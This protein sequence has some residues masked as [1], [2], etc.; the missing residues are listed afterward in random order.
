M[1]SLIQQLQNSL[2]GVYL[3]YSLQIMHLVT[4][5]FFLR[6]TIL[7]TYRDTLTTVNLSSYSH[8]TVLEFNIVKSKFPVIYY[9][10]ANLL[11][12]TMNVRT[13]RTIGFLVF[14][15]KS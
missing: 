13:Y 1:F 14:L 4:N 7:E 2:L 5:L 3:M 6:F 11:A 8:L 10:V 15:L 9:Y 12:F